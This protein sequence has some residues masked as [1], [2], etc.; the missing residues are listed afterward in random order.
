MD[1]MK[2]MLLKRTGPMDSG[3]DPLELAG[4]PLPEP[5]DDEALAIWYAE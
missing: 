3:S 2:A 5:A 4:I 1:G